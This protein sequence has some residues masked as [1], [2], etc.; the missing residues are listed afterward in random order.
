[1][2]NDEHIPEPTSLEEAQENL[3]KAIENLRYFEEIN[4]GK[5]KLPK[6]PPDGKPTPERDVFQ[7]LQAKH[8]KLKNRMKRAT[9]DVWKWEIGRASCRER[10]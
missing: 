4:K 2:G 10:V 8:Q 1:M 7:G 5:L 3:K 6:L 9:E